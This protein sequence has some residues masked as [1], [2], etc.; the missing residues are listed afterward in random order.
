MRDPI[1]LELESNR[2]AYWGKLEEAAELMYEAAEIHDLPLASAQ[3]YQRAG[4]L[5]AKVGREGR[6]ARSFIK[7][8]KSYKAISD[9]LA[10]NSLK[11]ATKY[12]QGEVS[13]PFLRLALEHLLT[14]NYYIEALEVLEKLVAV[15]RGAQRHRYLRRT[16]YALLREIAKADEYGSS[17]SYRLSLR[18]RLLKVAKEVLPISHRKYYREYLKLLRAVVRR[19]EREVKRFSGRF[20]NPLLRVDKHSYQ[21][22]IW[23]EIRSLL[24]ERERVVAA[25]TPLAVAGELDTLSRLL[26]EATAVHLSIP[27]DLF[28]AASVYLE[29]SERVGLLKVCE[30]TV[31][32]KV[33]ALFQRADQELVELYQAILL[34]RLGDLWRD[35]DR[36]RSEELYKVA[37]KAYALRGDTFTTLKVMV[38]LADL[39]AE[40][41][42]ERAALYYNRAKIHLK[43]H[44]YLL[45]HNEVKRKLARLVRRLRREGRL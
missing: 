33:L 1:E 5:Y 28:R 45:E 36:R 12:L 4:E 9:L 18:K 17:I 25:L 22:E 13:L 37:M 27:L 3:C 38:K 35:Y 8:Y 44:G 19:A 7:A 32:R 40:H 16:F 29:E 26:E 20:V 31:L 30:M 10:L 6:A 24:E 2:L 21:Q 43:L 23:E 14:R 11:T 34:E 39:L 41:E 15:S 42:P